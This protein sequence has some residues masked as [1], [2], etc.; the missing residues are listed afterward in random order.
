M[1]RHTQLG[2]LGV[3]GA[4]AV[5]CWFLRSSPAALAV[6]LGAAAFVALLGLALLCR[7]RQVAVPALML[8]W[9]LGVESF[10]APHWVMQLG[11]VEYFFIQ[12]VDHWPEGAGPSWNRHFLRGA[13]EPEEYTEDSFNTLFLGDSFTYGMK[14]KAGEAFPA[15]VG[16]RLARQFPEADIKVANFGW[17][18][19]SPLLSHRR[20]V[21]IGDDYA[22][23][24]IVLCLDM[25]D[26]ADDIRYENMLAKRGIYRLYE[27]LPLTI[28]LAASVAP[29]AYGRLVAWSVGAPVG[30][31]FFT[32]AP[33]D[34]TR[35]HLEPITENIG[36]I[37]EWAAARDARFLLAVLPRSFQHSEREC[38]DNWE[39]DEYETLGQYSLEIFR[40]FDEL[41]GSVD[42][43]IFSLLPTFEK[44]EEFPLCFD[45]DPHWTP[46]GHRVAATALVKV[47]A[48]LGPQ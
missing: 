3:A 29:G 16:R 47:L 10:A 7:R 14:V 27:W 23:D 43:P 4:L 44:T 11:L 13:E 37:A 18:S 41:Q 36:R 2:G 25:T 12:D 30:R 42:Y 15:V 45:D 38:P 1:S 20:L 46:L 24:L 22:P 8:V 39:A 34:D 40:Y 33:L 31:F 5:T 9:W 17:T 26:P 6:V 19:S 28:R 48:P 32:E 35:A 21:E